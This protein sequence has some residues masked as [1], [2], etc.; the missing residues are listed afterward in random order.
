MQIRRPTIVAFIRFLPILPLVV[1]LLARTQHPMYA[2]QEL[3]VPGCL[4]ARA[5]ALN[6]RR[7]VVGWYSTA[8]V[9]MQAILWQNGVATKLGTLGGLRSY[10]N[11]INDAGQ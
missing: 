10:A 6:N 2:I 5:L 7:Q 3:S 4:D 8:T 11:G 9:S 1:F